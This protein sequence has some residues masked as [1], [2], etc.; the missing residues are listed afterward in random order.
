MQKVNARALPNMRA[1]ARKNAWTGIAS[2]KP[3][4]H[5][6]QVASNKIPVLQTTTWFEN[7]TAM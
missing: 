1:N 3:F 5:H 6:T 2:P 7:E 4:S